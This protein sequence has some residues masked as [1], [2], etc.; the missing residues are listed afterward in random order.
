M[1]QY[2]Y[3]NLSQIN[4]IK[5]EK[6][7]FRFFWK[8]NID[9]WDL[10]QEALWSPYDLKDEF[11]IRKAYHDFLNDKSKK[12]VYLKSPVDHFIDFSKML[13][14][15]KHDENKQRV[16][17]RCNP[18]L[19]TNIVRINR[20]E[21][22]DFSLQTNNHNNMD[23]ID[24]IKIKNKWQCLSI[25]ENLNQDEFKNIFKI[26][27]NIFPEFQYKLEIEEGLCIF[28]NNFKIDI[29]LEE[30]K[31]ILIEEISNLGKEVNCQPLDYVSELLNIND[32]KSFFNKIV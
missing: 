22:A 14:I 25:F 31:L 10:N 1:I 26:Y 11:I 16:V 8:S 17:Q 5:L 20:F 13:Q 30:M 12:Y 19:V 6:I 29:T 3:L 32:H 23:V 28:N 15:N 4:P 18:K 24:K 7:K 2:S 27:F 21:T 9:P